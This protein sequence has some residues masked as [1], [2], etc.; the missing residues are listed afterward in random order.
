MTPK[1]QAQLAMEALDQAV[2]Y[3]QD[4]LDVQTG[5]AAGIF[6]SG[7]TS[8]QVMNAFVQYISLELSLK[9]PL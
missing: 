8:E 5:D 2:N 3:I 9:E 7:N 4:K 6:F 1:A